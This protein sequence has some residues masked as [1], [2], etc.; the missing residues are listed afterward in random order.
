[1]MNAYELTGAERFLS[2][3]KTY[4][5]LSVETFLSDQSPLPKASNQSEH[6]EAITGGP[7]LMENMLRLWMVMNPQDRTGE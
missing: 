6:Y 3:A 7:E 1:M 5:D 4:M 2:K